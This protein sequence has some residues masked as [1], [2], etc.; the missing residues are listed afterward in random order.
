MLRHEDGNM[1]DRKIEDRKIEQ[2][3]PPIFLSSM[4]LSSAPHCAAF[5]IRRPKELMTSPESA[6]EN[7][8]NLVR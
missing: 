4:F 7:P 2:N 3:F 8:C 1:A 6:A 5:A